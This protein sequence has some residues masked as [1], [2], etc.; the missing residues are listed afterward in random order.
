MRTTLDIERKL[1]EE[2]VVL[3]GERNKSKAVSKALAEYIRRKRIEEL[4]AM[5][6]KIE[7]VD[8]LKELEELEIKEMA[9]VQW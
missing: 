7:M 2:V 5:A 8:N 1:L 3:T 6:G 9:H 4:K